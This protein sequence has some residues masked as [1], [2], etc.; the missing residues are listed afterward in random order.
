MRLW[1]C[2]GRPFR[3]RS[4]VLG[5]LRRL[6]ART[7]EPDPSPPPPWPPCDRWEDEV[8]APLDQ[9]EGPCSHCGV[10]PYL[11]A[12]RCGTLDGPDDDDFWIAPEDPTGTRCDNCGRTREEHVPGARPNGLDPFGDFS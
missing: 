12:K 6:F 7:P 2:P 1:G 4:Y 3:G 11:H 9:P 8:A 5:F 10:M